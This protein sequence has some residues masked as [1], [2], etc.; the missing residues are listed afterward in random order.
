MVQ[1]VDSRGNKRLAGQTLCGQKC[2]N[3]CPMQRNVKQSKNGDNAR[4]LRGIYFINPND[5]ELKTHHEKTLV[6]RWKFR[7]QQ[8]CLVKHQQIETCR[9]IGKRKTKYACIV[10]ADESMR[11]RLEGMPHR[12]HEDHIAAK[13]AK[14]ALDK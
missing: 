1:G 2:G 8:Q 4:R 11:I 12:Y 10:D 3:T 7:C 6:E 13:E 9:N 5:E 14:A